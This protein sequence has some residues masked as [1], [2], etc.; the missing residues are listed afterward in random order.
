ML[1][2]V[3]TLC[4]PSE[5]SPGIN[6]SFI[7]T[8]GRAG[9]RACSHMPGARTRTSLQLKNRHCSDCSS[10]IQA[11]LMEGFSSHRTVLG[12]ARGLG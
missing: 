10:K 12:E 7:S 11:L 9:G 6:A 1:V 2:P 8:W 4:F 3:H 5:P